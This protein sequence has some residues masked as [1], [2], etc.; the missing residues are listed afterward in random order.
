MISWA[1]DLDGTISADPLVYQDVMSAL[2]AKGNR[3]WVMT[4]V[5]GKTVKPGDTAAKQDYMASMGITR[6]VHYT[7]LLVL[8]EDPG[9]GHADG[10]AKAL[11]ANNVNVLVDNDVNNVKAARL[12]GV[13][14]FLAFNSK[15]KK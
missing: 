3:V 8:A 12:E 9:G 11:V 2:V 13:I 4:G 7:D 14:T 10:K 6:S 15:Q 1:F 5:H